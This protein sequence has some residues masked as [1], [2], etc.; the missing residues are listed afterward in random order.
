MSDD[1]LKGC[2]GRIVLTNQDDK[3]IHYGCIPASALRDHAQT[4]YD[5]A[6]DTRYAGIVEEIAE[7]VNGLSDYVDEE[8][9]AE[10]KELAE[11]N[12]N[13]AYESEGAPLELNRDDVLIMQGNGDDP[14]IFVIK[15][16]YYCYAPPCSP[17]APGA[18]YLLDADKEEEER[19]HPYQT[20]C[21]DASWF[22]EGKC[23]YKY[24]KFGD[25]EN[26]S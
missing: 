22:E 9:R 7:A 25:D 26:G 8:T 2:L 16:L 4:F 1:E 14:D 20:Y 23:P 15:S 13:E 19:Q 11:N 18:G 6:T 10:M 5:E 3:G 17:C 21:L 12:F 24:Y